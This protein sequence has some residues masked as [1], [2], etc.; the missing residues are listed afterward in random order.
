MKSLFVLMILAFATVT[1]SAQSRII[2]PG[3]TQ[4]DFLP[5]KLGGKPLPILLRKP[6]KIKA[7]TLLDSG[8]A[9]VGDYVEFQTMEAI[10]TSGDTPNDAREN[11][12]EEIFPK[13]TSIFGVVTARKHRHFPLVRGYVEIALEPLVTW[14]GREIQMGIRRRGTTNLTEKESQELTRREQETE[15]E[16]RRKNISKPC[17]VER[18]NCVGGRRNAE[19]APTVTA[20]AGAASAG[21]LSL[22]K[23]EETRFIA[24][25]GFFTL[26]KDLGNLLNG[27]DAEI[28]P[29]EIFDLVI[30]AG[31][32]FCKIPK[33]KPPAAVCA[34]PCCC[35][36]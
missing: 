33:P 29:N 16:K 36:K 25:T 18:E 26:A 8:T 1:A 24:A 4:V 3:Q 9:R 23:E 21:V 27:T 6:F 19:V 12:P 11:F 14:D 31:S 34:N 10:Y 13:S 22:A 30:K 35:A 7:M 2:R 17:R 32:S 28:A 15:K 5:C 20:V